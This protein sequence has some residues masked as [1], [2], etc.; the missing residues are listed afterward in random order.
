M[1]FPRRSAYLSGLRLL[2][3]GGSSH[4]CS[5]QAAREILGEGAEKL[6]GDSRQKPR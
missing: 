6:A 1:R 5:L 3:W 4:S 2:Q